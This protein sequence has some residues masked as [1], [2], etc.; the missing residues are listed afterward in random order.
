MLNEQAGK[1]SVLLLNGHN[2]KKN[3]SFKIEKSAIDILLHFT[4]VYSEDL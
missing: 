1:S 2:Y 3:Y 4:K